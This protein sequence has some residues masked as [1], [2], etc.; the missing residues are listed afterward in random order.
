VIKG[1]TKAKLVRTVRS[2]M[3]PETT[4]GKNY[5]Q[6]TTRDSL[7]V[8]SKTDAGSRRVGIYLRGGCDVPAMFAMAPQIQRTIVGTVAIRRD[9]IPISGSRSDLLL[10]GLDGLDSVPREALVDVSKMLEL[11]KRYFDADLFAPT[12]DVQRAKGGRRFDKNVIVLS[13]GPDFTRSIYRHREYGFL[14]DPGGYWLNSSMD[15]VLNDMSLV[16]AFNK[17][18]RKVGRMTPARFRELFGRLVTELKT[19]TGAH[20]LV[21]GLMTVDPSDLTH[22]YRL[23]RSADAARR[24]EFMIALAG[25]SREHGFDVVDVDRIL[26]L[27]GIEDQVDFAHFS[28]RQ[29]EPIG[30]EAY[31]ILREREIL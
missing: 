13:A 23:V 18:Y 8:S 16:E 14:V 17:S 2:I 26:K 15:K 5:V 7:V 4:S 29:F 20:I 21:L 1:K 9:A 3:K 27:G 19:R 11:P 25:L 28:Q 22:S 31:R 30:R 6:M 10:Q 24:R 12:F